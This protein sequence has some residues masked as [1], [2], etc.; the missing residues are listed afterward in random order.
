M[1]EPAVKN[2]V[3]KSLKVIKSI[4][5]HCIRPNLVN[6]KSFAASHDFSRI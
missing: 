3:L 6:E 2:I 1:V 5:V 4:C